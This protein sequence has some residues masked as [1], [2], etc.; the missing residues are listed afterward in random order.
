[1]SKISIPASNILARNR[2]FFIE[3]GKLINNEI[4]DQIPKIYDS[5]ARSR[6]FGVNAGQTSLPLPL[7]RIATPFDVYCIDINSQMTEHMRKIAS[8]SKIVR[9]ILDEDLMVLSMDGNGELVR[10]LNSINI[11]V[12][13][14]F[15][16]QVIGTNAAALTMY[17]K[18]N[19]CVIGEQHYIEAL[20]NYVS[21]AVVSKQEKETLYYLVFITP[22]E[23]F[24]PSMLGFLYYYERSHYLNFA[25]EQK[26]MECSISENVIK[27]V[28]KGLLYVDPRDIILYVSDWL[29]GFIGLTQKNVIGDK[30][31]R[32]FPEIKEAVEAVRN[33]KDNCLQEIYIGSC[34]KKDHFYVD[35]RA[36]CKNGY[37]AKAVMVT[38]MPKQLT[39]HKAA[40]N[41]GFKAR[42]TF[43][44]LAGCSEDF[45][46]AVYLAQAAANSCSSVLIEGETGTGKELFAHAI[47]NTSKR[48]NGPF[49]S[50][51]CAAIPRELIGSELFGYM[52]G[53]FTG[54]RRGGAVGKFEM[55]HKGTIFLDEISEMPYDLQ[56]VLLRVL[57]ERKVTRLGGRQS[58]PV[59]VRI[60]AATNRDLQALANKEEFRM[61]LYYRLNV[62]NIEIPPLRKRLDDIPLLVD[63]ILKQC[64]YT[65][66]KN[67]LGVTPEVMNLFKSFNW[68]GNVRELRNVV[69][70]GINFCT[71]SLITLR[72]LPKKFVEKYSADPLVVHNESQEQEYDHYEKQLLWKLMKE[73]RGNKSS[74]AHK[75]GI[76]RPTLYNKLKK[77]KIISR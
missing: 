71:S 72:D 60:I 73:Y 65:I 50:I 25:Y 48:K 31:D 7:Q 23:N 68:P 59:D 38:F 10:I 20:Q 77:Y 62:I 33:G 53:A 12:G 42:Y 36:A 35:I 66:G 69:E 57:E 30:L 32:L 9:L 28:N 3:N 70:S 15:A 34:P 74:V 5:W 55:A 44:D 45:Q 27:E 47:H 39:K 40:E 76:S 26:K 18:Q 16:E 21:C 49:I 11:C 64:S 24:H 8:D 43:A 41:A 56:A 51:N 52:E 63:H 14:S 1:M 67:V 2:R 58:I 17:S 13:A 29:A 61:D 75:L 4:K 54:A 22:K 37:A 19:S 46:E 6:A